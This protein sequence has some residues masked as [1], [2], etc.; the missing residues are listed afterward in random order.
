M[1]KREMKEWVLLLN[2]A[3]KDELRLRI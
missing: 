3:K 1:K 2:K